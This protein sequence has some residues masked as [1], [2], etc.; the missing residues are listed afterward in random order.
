MVWRVVYSSITMK[1]TR[2][3]TDEKIKE[4]DE[5]EARERSSRNE[6]ILDRIAFGKI[7]PKT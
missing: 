7:Q 6:W 4:R 1:K 5:R 3:L 2:V